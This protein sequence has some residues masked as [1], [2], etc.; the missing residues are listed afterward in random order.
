MNPEEYLLRNTAERRR[1]E[2]PREIVARRRRQQ[3]ACKT[4]VVEALQKGEDLTAVC[5]RF[6]LSRTAV[7][8]LCVS[9][10]KKGE[11]LPDHFVS[12]SRGAA[13][14]EYMLNAGTLSV[15][16]LMEH[17]SWDEAEIRAVRAW[18]QGKGARGEL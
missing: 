7:V 15:K 2:S 13:L 9:V 1:G 11:M 10:L 4:E 18:L 3:K 14:E 8:K 5:E 6:A 12:S 16:K 17:S